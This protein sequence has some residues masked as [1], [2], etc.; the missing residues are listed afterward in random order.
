MMVRLT[1]VTSYRYTEYQTPHGAARATDVCFTFKGEPWGCR[2]QGIL[3][4]RELSQREEQ[5][6]HRRAKASRIW[7]GR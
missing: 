7:S 3:N 4:E 6:F 5:F 2:F 1:N